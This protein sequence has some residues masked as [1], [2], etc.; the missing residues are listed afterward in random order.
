MYHDPLPLGFREGEFKCMGDREFQQT[1]PHKLSFP[2]FE[3]LEPKIWLDKCVNYCMVYHV[4]G[5]IWVTIASIYMEGNTVHVFKI[6]KLHNS[7]GSCRDFEHAMMQK[8]GT[9]E[10][11]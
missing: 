6:F 2:K 11:S 7:L 4:S 10:Y 3:G 8:F 1:P 9:E 5:A